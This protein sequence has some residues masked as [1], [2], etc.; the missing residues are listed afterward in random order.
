MIDEATNKAENVYSK[1]NEG[2]PYPVKRP[3]YK[4]DDP[5][6]FLAL[7]KDGKVRGSYSTDP[8]KS[9]EN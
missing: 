2:T 5:L 7:S 9:N 3:Y 8:A 1:I 4:E 6:E